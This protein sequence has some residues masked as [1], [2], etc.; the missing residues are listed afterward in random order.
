MGIFYNHYLEVTEV[1]KELIVG[2]NF[3]L[4]SNI[5]HLQ[6]VTSKNIISKCA[7]IL[8]YS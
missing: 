2:H 5:F 6:D 7:V 1:V 8:G 3:P 4:I